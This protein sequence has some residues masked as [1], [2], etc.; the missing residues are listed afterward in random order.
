MSLCTPTKILG[1]SGK[2]CP[3]IATERVQCRAPRASQ[4]F[5]LPYQF[6]ASISVR[7]MVAQSSKK[8]TIFN[9]GPRCTSHSSC[10]DGNVCTVDT[11]VR[12]QCAFEILSGC[13]ST[14]SSLKNRHTVYTYKT[15]LANNMAASQRYFLKFVYYSIL[16]E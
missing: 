11:C 14:S 1:S 10:Q 15:F 8:Q 13:S 16:L 5:A 7:S 2:V 9:T 4:K 6:N 12:G 3:T